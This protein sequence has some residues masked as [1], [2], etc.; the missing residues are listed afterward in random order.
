MFSKHIFSFIL[1]SMSAWAFAGGYPQPVVMTGETQMADTAELHFD[2]APA[3][4][5]TLVILGDHSKIPEQKY[6]FAYDLPA[7][8]ASGVDQPVSIDFTNKAKLTI[9]CD[10]LSDNCHSTD[11]VTVGSATFSTLWKVTQR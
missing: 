3:N 9:V 1:F 7:E 4:T 8:S 2:P 6:R 10:S 11:Y 5:G